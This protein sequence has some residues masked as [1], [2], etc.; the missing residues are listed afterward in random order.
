MYDAREIINHFKLQLMPFHITYTYMYKVLVLSMG[1]KIAFFQLPDVDSSDGGAVCSAVSQITC[2][3][4][5][6]DWNFS[7]H[8]CISYSFP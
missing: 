3:S 7:L 4:P 5:I 6:F 1:N 8:N 2:S